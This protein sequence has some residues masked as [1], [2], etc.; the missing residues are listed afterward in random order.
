MNEVVYNE[1]CL[2][3]LLC[4]YTFADALRFLRE[5]FQTGGAPLQVGLF[6]QRVQRGLEYLHTT[7]SDSL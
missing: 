3:R 4:R 1:S 6:H 5:D 2:L 7:V